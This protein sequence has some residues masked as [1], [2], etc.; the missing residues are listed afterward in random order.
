METIRTIYAHILYHLW[1][2]LRGRVFNPYQ[3]GGA[4]LHMLAGR[5]SD[6]LGYAIIQMRA[7][8]LSAD[9]RTLR[10]KLRVERLAIERSL[11]AVERWAPLNRYDDDGE[12]LADPSVVEAAYTDWARER[13]SNASWAEFTKAHPEVVYPP[14]VN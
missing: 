2:I 3:L 10:L 9:T 13:G 7:A 5:A 4:D 8:E 12:P 1:L 6:H 14:R 11:D